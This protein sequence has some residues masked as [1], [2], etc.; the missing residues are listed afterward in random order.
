VL[1]DHL[2]SL[3]D[4]P[5]PDA[6]A[7]DDLTRSRTWGE[8]SERVARVATW[9]REERGLHP[10]NHLAAVMGNRV[11]LIE[12][13]LGSLVAGVWLTPV[14]WH[15]TPDEAAFIVGDADARL[16]VVDPEFE[17]LGRAAA[18]ERPVVMA[19]EELDR[20]LG[21][22]GSRTS[23]GPV[24]ASP[25]GGNM[26]YTSGTTG[27]PKGV[28]RAVQPTVAEQLRF[29]ARS[30]HPLGLDGSGP[31]LVTGPLYH[32]APLGF[33]VM[34]LLNGAPVVL[35]PRWDPSAALQLIEDRSI[36][37]THLVPTM[38][39]RLLRLPQARR[40]AFDPSS[41][42]V[43]L[44][45]AAP[46]APSV[47]QQMIEWWGP[48]LVEYWGASE[49]GVV[50]LVDSAGWLAHPGTVGRALPTYEVY[51]GDREGNPLPAGTEGLLWCRSRTGKQVFRYHN[52]PEATDRAYAGPG[53]YTIG[54]IGYVDADGW[55]YLSD[56]AAHTIISGGVNIYPAEVEAVLIEHP[57]VADVAVFGIP[58]EEWGEEVKAAVEVAEGVEATPALERE[59]LDL[60][61]QRLAGY[62]VPRSIDFEPELPRHPTGKLFVRQLRD[63]YWRDRDRRI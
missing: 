17:A 15:L 28:K 22:L 34:D 12:L 42:S 31:H 59:L 1:V 55:V 9:L 6:V 25:A 13:V 37:H 29:L 16:L 61:R 26:F 36:R 50:T 44:H 56:R 23:G 5:S 40:E 3:P 48:V 8:L 10:G 20:A 52:A 35:M 19:G 27:R 47:K 41:L 14:N 46:I 57:A 51:A 21:A 58:N 54:D 33:A 4:P 63:R 60:A 32:A 39:V 62:K 45:G 49:G 24:G 7:L 2:A 18:G 53:T 30:G 43:V 38:F 11:E